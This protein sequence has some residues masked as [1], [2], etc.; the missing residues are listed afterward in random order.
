MTAPT[1]EELAHRAVAGD[2]DAVAGV[3]RALERPMYALSLRMLWHPQDAEDA[4]QEILVRVITRLSRFDFRSSLKTWAY[5]VAA[6]YLLDVRKSCA[7]RQKSSFDSFSEALLDGL[8]NEGPADT[9]RSLLTEEVRVGCTLAMLQCLDRPHRLAYLLGEIFDLPAVEAA[10]AMGLEPAAF[11]KR[12]QRARE[13][14]EEFTRAH[15][16][17]VN[18]EAACACHRRVPEAIRIGRISPGLP[19]H[20]SEGTSFAEA[21]AVIARVKNAERVVELHRRSQPERPSREIARLVMA[22]LEPTAPGEASGQSGA[23]CAP[24]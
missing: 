16:G 10:E 3:V 6:N 17:L 7:E 22:M 19:L 13:S 5:R 21:R 20:A 15:C 18:D 4:T 14:I 8:S 12:L 2:S 24:P 1:L 11:R 23:P 9:E